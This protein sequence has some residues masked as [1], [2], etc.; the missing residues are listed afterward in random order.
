MLMYKSTKKSRERAEK[1]PFFCNFR[2]PNNH[3]KMKKTLTL[4]LSVLLAGGVMLSA[5]TKEG[6]KF[7]YTEASQ[8]TLTGKLF[9]DT[10]NPYHRVD[11]VIHKGFTQRENLQVRESS[12][13]AVAFRTNSTAITVR[14]VYGQM[15]YPT[16]TNGIAARGYDLYIRQGKEWIFA[17]A[18]V[19]GNGNEGKTLTLIRDMDGSTHE[20]LLYLPLYSEVNSVR[21]GVE[22]GAFIEALPNPFRYRVGIFGSSYTHGSSTSRGGMTYPAQFTRKTGIQLL[23]LGCSGNSK[24]QPYFAKALAAADVDAYVFDS[25]SNPDAKMIEERLFPF[26][27]TI[28]AA[29]P[30][31][32]LIFQRTIRRESRNFNL[33][34]EEKEAAKQAMS[35]SLM[36]I[37]CKKYKN[38]YYIVPNASA[39]DHL[40]SV[41]GTHPTNYGYTLWEQS[42]EKKILRILRKYCIK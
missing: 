20:C 16:N 29:H 23:S 33:V 6:V 35:D 7:H 38:V 9:P 30:D 25:F 12:G 15:E 34:V 18:R 1:P 22:D 42:V 11:T 31:I 28:Q 37:A 2:M 36:A 39:K 19:Q 13:L 27:E 17:A 3:R 8:L 14:T 32:P 5:Q 21:I 40:A 24:L 4:I 26:I 41:D 10:P